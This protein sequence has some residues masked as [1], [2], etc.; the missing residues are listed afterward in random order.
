[1]SEVIALKI[2]IV[3]AFTWT[4]FILLKNY[5]KYLKEYYENTFNT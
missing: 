2:T 3:I 1:M 5:I 4:L